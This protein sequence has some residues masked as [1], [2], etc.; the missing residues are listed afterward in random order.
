FWWR[1][2]PPREASWA[3]AISDTKLVVAKWR[4]T[5]HNAGLSSG[6]AHDREKGNAREEGNDAA[7][8]YRESGRERCSIHDFAEA[9]SGTRLDPAER[10]VEHRLRRRGRHG[11]Q[12]SDQSGQ[13]KHRGALRCGLGLHG[14]EPFAAGYGR[15]QLEG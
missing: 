1:A 11:P 10:Y 13:P 12:Q 2:H 8:L 14:Q 6:G 15:F 5:R 4:A 3:E 7:Q 9:R